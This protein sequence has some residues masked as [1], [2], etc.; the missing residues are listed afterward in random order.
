M[1]ELHHDVLHLFFFERPCTGAQC[2]RQGFRDSS[3]ASVGH[4]WWCQGVLV[5][6]SLLIHWCLLHGLNMFNKELLSI[7]LQENVHKICQV[8]RHTQTTHTVF[9]LLD[10]TNTSS[11]LS[12]RDAFRNLSWTRECSC[13]MPAVRSA[14]KS[15]WS[16]TCLTR[17]Y[18]T[19]LCIVELGRTTYCEVW[20]GW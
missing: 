7:K 10:T 11:M 13:W 14:I 9:T 12:R 3:Q 2:F 6:V 1:H 4:S 18:L 16:W 15:N 17:P 19:L 8:Q 5:V 20:R